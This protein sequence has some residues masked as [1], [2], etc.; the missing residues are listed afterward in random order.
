MEQVK[1]NLN[2]VRN[3][4]K[5]SVNENAL[6][7]FSCIQ[8][9]INDIISVIENKNSIERDNGNLV[10]VQVFMSL[11]LCINILVFFDT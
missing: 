8:K 4:T 7:D 10:V 9:C 2:I 1:T 3:E 11:I 6:T 5:C